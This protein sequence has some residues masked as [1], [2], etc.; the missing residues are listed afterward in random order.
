MELNPTGD[1]SQVVFLRGQYWGQPCLIFLL[2]ILKYDNLIKF[3]D[4]TMLEELSICLRIGRPCRGIWI[5]W[6]D[7]LRP[8]VCTLTRPSAR[9]CNLVTK[10]PIIATGLDGKLHKEKYLGLLVDSWLNMRQ[11]C[12]HVAKEDNSIQA[13]IRNIVAGPGR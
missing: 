2:I 1:R 9:S 8:I 6:I 5:G 12:A 13:C 3:T 7:G 10:I 4:D 11:Q